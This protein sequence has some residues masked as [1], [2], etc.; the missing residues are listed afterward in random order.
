MDARGEGLEDWMIE[1]QLIL[2]NKPDDTT[3][4]FSRAWKS[5]STPDL[6]MATDDIQFMLSMV[7]VIMYW[8]N[9]STEDQLVYL[10][11]E[12]KM[13]SKKRRRYLLSM[14][15]GPKPLTESEGGP[16]TKA[17]TKTDK[18]INV[19]LDTNFLQHRTA[20]FHLDGH[21]SHRICRQQ[22]VPQGGIIS[23]TLF[24]VFINGIADGLS[25]H[26]SRAINAY[27]LAIWNAE[28]NLLTA[29][30]RMQ[31]VLNTVAAWALSWGVVI[32]ET[33]TVASIF[34]LSTR[35]EQTDLQINENQILVEDTPTYLGLKLD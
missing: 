25:R 12:L 35:P 24:L 20:L 1:N 21:I 10:A 7:V 15:T 17:I 16:S 14:L 6:A 28:K 19:S 13:L 23:K 31:E 11:Q 9:H 2:I 8:K 18:R 5:L 34:S 26:I 33:K 4:F 3:T 22:G 30:F 27:D 29:T 32:N